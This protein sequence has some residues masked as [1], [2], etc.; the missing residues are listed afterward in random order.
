MILAAAV[1]SAVL[2][3]KRSPMAV[4]GEPTGTSGWFDVVDNSVPRVFGSAVQKIAV[5]VPPGRYLA[6][7]RGKGCTGS[8]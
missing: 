7:V 6:V 8:E 2:V 4:A 1:A 5:A 3:V